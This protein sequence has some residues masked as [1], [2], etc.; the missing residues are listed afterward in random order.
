MKG[1]LYIV[2]TPIGNLEDVTVRA[3]RVLRDVDLIAAEDT[4]HTK[5]LLSHYDI[6]KRMISYWGEKEKV[7]AEEVINSLK[8]GQD[9]ALV[10]D[11]GTP[12]ISDPGEVVIRRAAEEGIE[13]VPV[14]GPS[15]II[16][17]LSVS[18][19]DTREFLFIGFLSPKNTQ[20]LKKLRELRFEK[21]TLIFYEA[22]HRL[23][24]FLA[25]MRDVLGERRVTV[26]HELTKFNEKVYRGN[27]STILDMLEEEVIAGEYVIITEGYS[28]EEYSIE[29]ALAEVF[30]LM[31][32]GV[33]RKQ[34]VRAVSSQYGLSRRMLYDES[35]KREE[36]L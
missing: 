8:E 16:T 18:G 9:V 35:L 21:R 22:P 13:I 15:A 20:R 11:A 10:T 12:G 14:P 33:G 25:D 1:I 34:A 31:K 26:C 23:L 36:G 5:K 30:R 3:L 2:A 28:S 17:A 7:R 19:L 32:N 4:R 24:E 29:E 27:L 6:S